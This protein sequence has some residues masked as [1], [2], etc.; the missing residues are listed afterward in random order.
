MR[1]SHSARIQKWAGKSLML[2]FALLSAIALSGATAVAQSVSFHANGAFASASSCAGQ[3]IVE[4]FDVFVAGGS[5]KGQQGTYLEYHHFIDDLT[6]D[7]LQRD[8]GFGTIPNSAFKVQGQTDVLNVDTNTV[9]YFFSESCTFGPNIETCT[10]N[11]PIGIVTGTWT[12][13]GGFAVQRT[14]TVR[15]IFPSFGSV[16]TT[17]T[18][19]DSSAVA[20]LTVLGTKLTTT[21]AQ[22]G[23]NHNTTIT[24]TH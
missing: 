8:F 23:T 15:L 18:D 17:G 22:I 6:T 19:D 21:F 2:I 3:L 5:V 9:A 10:E 24:V 7:V 1:P 16:L 11:V 20:S 13:I 4:C 14:G 12:G